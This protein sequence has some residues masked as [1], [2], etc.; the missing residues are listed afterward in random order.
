[1]FFRSLRDLARPQILAIVDTLK[2]S[3]GLPVG[4]IAESLKMSY[5]GVKQYCI[6]LEKRGYLDT[7]RRP[8]ETGR[9][10]LTYRLTPKAHV[11]FPQHATE[12]CLD[13]LEA[14]RQLHGATAA[15]KIL[16]QHFLKKT[17]AYAKKIKGQSIVE[18]ATSLAK[19]RDADGHCAQIDYDP[20]HGLR[21]TEYHSPLAELIQ[22]F[23]SVAR[24]EE[25]MLSRL[26]QVPVQREAASVSGLMRITFLIAGATQPPP[27]PP[28]TGVRSR[29]TAHRRKKSTARALP[30]AQDLPAAEPPAPE[31]L[32]AASSA[33][34]SSAADSPA[35][36]LSALETPAAEPTASTAA[37]VESLVAGAVDSS[38]G[39]DRVQEERP[40]APANATECTADDQ[41]AETQAVNEPE[42]PSNFT[43]PIE[44]AP[45]R[46]DPIPAE[47]ALASAAPAPTAADHR[48]DA[49]PF[50]FAS[51]E[52]PA[53]RHGTRVVAPAKPAAKPA[54]PVAEELFLSL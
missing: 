43:N 30:V 46:T 13:V 26:L 54:G 38:S 28:A 9:P 18:R 41:A 12:L 49:E 36:A 7:W 23:P 29:P 35:P 34:A 33:A 37:I 27:S 47:P 2:R 14:V 42:S 17:D 48:R 6:E 40:F 15:D 3:D 8:R 25:A 51:L 31:S 19:L 44:L 22:G 20:Q 39:G 5:M 21:L 16:Y 10:E 24:M 11:L 50:L 53:P 52:T 4:D 32:A 45:T 1:M